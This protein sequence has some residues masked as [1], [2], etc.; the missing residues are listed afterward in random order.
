MPTNSMHTRTYAPSEVS[1]PTTMRP[2]PLSPTSGTLRGTT[3]TL[4]AYPP[5]AELS[6]GSSKV[7]ISFTT[8]FAT[9]DVCLTGSSSRTRQ[10]GYAV[11]SIDRNLRPTIYR[12]SESIWIDLWA[13]GRLKA[14]S[15]G[16]VLL[17]GGS[18]RWNSLRR[19]RILESDSLRR[20]HETFHRDTKCP[21]SANTEACLPAE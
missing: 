20:L 13:V 9:L 1:A 3:R 7:V 19:L 21:T 14:L 8:L 15:T 16:S 6:T 12:P 4:P 17:S 11:L 10:H 2:A 5:K 18:V